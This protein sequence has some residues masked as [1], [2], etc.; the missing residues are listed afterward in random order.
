[1]TFSIA[2]RCAETGAFGV[3]ITSSSICVASRCAFVRAGTGAALTQ[4]ITDPRLGPRALDL[5]AEGLSA[6]EALQ[7]IAA[8]AQNLAWRQLAAVDRTGGTAHY[9]GAKALGTHAVAEGE[10]CIALG[11]LLADPGVPRAMITGFANAPGHLALRLLIGLESGLAA[12]GEEGPVRSAG[13]L[14]ADRQPW[15]VVDLRVDWHDRPLPTLRA[16][17]TAYAPQLD[18]YVIR[19]LDPDAAPTFDVPGDL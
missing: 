10:G 15:P 7:Q 3:A 5:M 9:T 1:M 2:A 14:V 8:E 13:L 19:A 4:N 18:A 17:W 6:G 12:G 11:N 16:L